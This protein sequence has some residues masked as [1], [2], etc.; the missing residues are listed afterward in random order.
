[1]YPIRGCETSLPRLLK[2]KHSAWP[3]PPGEQLQGRNNRTC[4]L[5]YAGDASN[6]EW[7]AYPVISTVS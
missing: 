2:F 5:V 6:R 1:M 3:M 4:Q 7:P